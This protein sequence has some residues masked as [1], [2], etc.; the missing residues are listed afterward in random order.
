MNFQLTMIMATIFI[1]YVVFIVLKFGVLSSIS[2]SSY[3][4]EGNWR[5]LF[6]LWLAILAIMNLWQGLGVWGGLTSI[7]FTWAG[8]TLNHKKSD[9]LYD[10][11]HTAGTI[12]AILSALGGLAFLHG[13]YL[14]IALS[15]VGAYLIYKFIFNWIFWTEC[16]LMTTIVMGYLMR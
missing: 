13:I 9:K 15:A 8:L 6:F 14:P 7:G 11:I 16:W 3:K 4:L 1:L 12:G 5:F 10:E 2:A